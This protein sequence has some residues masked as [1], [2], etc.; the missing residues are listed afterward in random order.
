[1]FQK[2]YAYTQ[3]AKS[4]AHHMLISQAVSRELTWKWSSYALQ[5]FQ[6]APLASLMSLLNM[7]ESGGRLGRSSWLPPGP[8]LAIV[9]LGGV[10]QQVVAAS[11]CVSFSLQF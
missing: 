2:A 11:L 3:G 7:C 1:M 8:V 5:P 9:T 10:S 6:A 4:L